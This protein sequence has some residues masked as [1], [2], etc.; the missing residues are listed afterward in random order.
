[1]GE[2]QTKPRLY[3][4]LG[5][6]QIRLIS[7]DR[8]SPTSQTIACRLITHDLDEAPP[9]KALSYVWGDP[10]VT[11]TI[12]INGLPVEKTANLVAALSRLRD[13]DEADYWIDAICIDQRNKAEKS[14]QVQLMG[15]IYGKAVEATAWLGPGTDDSALAMTSLAQWSM[16]GSYYL[17]LRKQIQDNISASTE[18]ERGLR[19]LVFERTSAMRDL[20]QS[21][22]RTIHNPYGVAEGQALANLFQRPYWKRIWIIQ[23]LTLSRHVTLH[24]GESECKF[25][26]FVP[27]VM[28]MMECDERN[29][30]IYFGLDGLEPVK[31]H[32]SN[33]VMGVQPT[34]LTAGGATDIMRHNLPKLLQMTASALAT[35]PRD[36]VYAL[37]SLV[38]PERTVIKVDYSKTPAKVYADFVL[39]EIQTNSLSPLYMVQDE[40]SQRA[41]KDI[42][43]WVPDLGSETSFKSYLD[44]LSNGD[45]RA[46]GPS[47]A[48][49]DVSWR[50][51]TLAVRGYDT[52]SLR[53]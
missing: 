21:V 52:V 2:S 11:C 8:S 17:L 34:M 7:I 26:T 30:W 39:S 43:S 41:T 16:A 33:V 14:E 48:E 15:E 37:L 42:P 12:T 29:M 20:I 51:K 46:A 50:R 24:C 45:Y 47:K 5:K 44:R 18:A 28:L 31:L 1:M 6:R 49:Y 38:P 10:E 3:E 22:L 32:M 25:S 13:L 40:K 4:P 27:M 23:E 9:Y 35:N 53:R 19:M 36:K